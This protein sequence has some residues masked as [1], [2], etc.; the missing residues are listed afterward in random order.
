MVRSLIGIILASALLAG[1]N[2]LDLVHMV[3][4]IADHVDSRVQ[5]SLDWNESA[6]PVVIPTSASTYRFYACTD[7]HSLARTPENYSAMIQKESA[8][9]ASLFHLMLGDAMQLAEGLPYAAATFR[10]STH[11]GFAIVGNH[12]LFFNGWG[13]WRD[14]FH[15]S[16]YY[17]T[18]QGPG[19]KDLYIMLDSASGTHGP[20]QTKWLKDVL[21]DVRPT[22]RHCFVATH[23]N[24]FRSDFTQFPSSNLPVDETY[25]FIDILS[26]GKVDFLLQGH[27]HVREVREIGGVTGLI[28]DTIKDGASNA[29]YFVATVGDEI[30]YEFAEP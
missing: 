16:T 13:T 25:A 5:E 21:Q 30:Q 3:V 11:P 9:A 23:T 26:K 1:C 6:G 2:Q 22:C 12:D 24:I 14:T 18:V 7:V 28:L 17:F 27:D 15:T 19:W 8:D 20:V 29:S 10:S 4:P